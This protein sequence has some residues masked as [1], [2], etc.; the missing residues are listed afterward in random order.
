MTGTRREGA[1]LPRAVFSTCGF[2]HWVA[3][4]RTVDQANAR[5]GGTLRRLATGVVWPSGKLTQ[6]HT[7][8]AGKSV[9]M[10]R[11]NS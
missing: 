1:A 4:T 2:A 9:T 3:L 11:V 8:H 7:A 10:G 6:L 5:Y